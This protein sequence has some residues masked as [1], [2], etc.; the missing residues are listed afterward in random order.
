V[1]H[2]C[3]G[4]PRRT[5]ECIGAD[6]SATLVVA[7]NDPA[8]RLQLTGRS[9]L[10]FG[11]IAPQ[12]PW[13]AFINSKD[14]RTPKPVASNLPPGDTLVVERW[15]RDAPPL[16]DAS[17]LNRPNRSISGLNQLKTPP[18]AERGIYKEIFLGYQDVSRSG[19]MNGSKLFR[20]DV[21]L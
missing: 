11:E 9:D 14:P 2:K 4:P 6:S 7:L 21:F 12:R 1:G 8:R 19:Q 5:L 13:S 20:L 3:F 18:N 15:F 17:N 16:L 10:V